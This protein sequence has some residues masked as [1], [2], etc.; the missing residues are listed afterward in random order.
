MRLSVI[1]GILLM[2]IAFGTMVWQSYFIRRKPPS[3]RMVLLNVVVMTMCWGVG[4]Y[5]LWLTG[6]LPNPRG[7]AISLIVWIIFWLFW[8][9]L[10]VYYQKNKGKPS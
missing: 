6:N 7:A 3:V 5:G 9:F 4:N 8:G 2:A 10:G 1:L